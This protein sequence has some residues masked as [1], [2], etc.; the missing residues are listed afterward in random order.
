MKP[1]IRRLQMSIEIGS[2]TL[3]L[4]INIANDLLQLISSWLVLII[5][6]AR[7]L[8]LNSMINDLILNKID[9][10][11]IFCHFYHDSLRLIT[12]FKRY[13]EGVGFLL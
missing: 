5:K 4:V 12:L 10:H 7:A 8:R 13:V 9:F 11:I 2:F 1:L 3:L 6:T